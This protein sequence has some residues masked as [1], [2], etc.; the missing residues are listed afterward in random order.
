MLHK[1]LK[2]LT[3]PEFLTEYI[4]S[5]TSQVC[6]FKTFISRPQKTP[7]TT[8]VLGQEHGQHESCPGTPRQP[9]QGES[10]LVQ[11]TDY[12]GP[13]RDC[14]LLQELETYFKHSY[15]VFL[16]WEQEWKE[17]S[18]KGIYDVCWTGQNQKILTFASVRLQGY[19]PIEESSLFMYFLI[20]CLNWAQHW[21]I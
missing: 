17:L 14:G 2:L 12:Q 10:Q 3:F 20:L 1:G 4:S 6:F 16:S 19:Q 15:F 11:R 13:V 21:T 7:Q 8:V 5:K 18:A 9:A